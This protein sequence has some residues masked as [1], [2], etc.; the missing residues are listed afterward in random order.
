MES[1]VD[2]VAQVVAFLGVF[3]GLGLEPVCPAEGHELHADAVSIK[4]VGPDC[5]GVYAV[6]TEHRV[7]VPA[8]LA[9]PVKWAQVP[10]SGR[11]SLSGK[12]RIYWVSPSLIQDSTFRAFSSA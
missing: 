3:K 2:D 5:H 1:W 4:F 12:S 11:I 10:S 6:C 8:T 7:W 9:R